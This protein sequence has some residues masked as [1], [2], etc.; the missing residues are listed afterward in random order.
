MTSLPPWA[1]RLLRLTCPRELYEH[2]EGD[3]IEMYNYEVGAMGKRR[4]KFSFV[5]KVIRFIRPGILLRNRLQPIPFFNLTAMLHHNIK[6]AF[7]SLR[8]ERLFAG[9][10]IAGLSIGIT[11]SLLILTWVQY[12]YSYNHFIRNYRDIYQVKVNLRYNDEIKTDEGNPL[13]SI[14][15]LEKEIPGSRTSVLHR[16]VTVTP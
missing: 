2:I 4:A 14:F 9:I 11:C 15:L 16:T 3:L 7:R 8:R 13:P 12:E 10:N 5:V 6:S 1:E